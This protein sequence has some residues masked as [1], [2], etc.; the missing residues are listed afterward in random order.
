MHN[1]HDQPV[2]PQVAHKFGS[3]P[4]TFL[5]FTLIS[6]LEII[7]AIPATH[8]CSPLRKPHSDIACPRR[9][10][11][12]HNHGLM[13]NQASKI[14][15]GSSDGPLVALQAAYITASLTPSFSFLQTSASSVCQYSK[16]HS[17]DLW[18]SSPPKPTESGRMWK[19]GQKGNR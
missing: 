5:F 2:A 9:D 7:I 1:L 10:K 4:P 11:R 14:G 18:L 13:L 6:L 15:I 12:H 3:S 16:S 19:W 8:G 17:T